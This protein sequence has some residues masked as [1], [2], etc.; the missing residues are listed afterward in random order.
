MHWTLTRNRGAMVRDRIRKIVG[1]KS[2]RKK[3]CL[4]KVTQ[5]KQN[6]L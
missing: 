2:S 1:T 3:K 5:E 6:L 4:E